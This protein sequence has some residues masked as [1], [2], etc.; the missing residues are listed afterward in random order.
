MYGICKHISKPFQKHAE[1]WFEQITA[2]LY[3]K[4]KGRGFF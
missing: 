4:V 1:Q 3:K 2:I